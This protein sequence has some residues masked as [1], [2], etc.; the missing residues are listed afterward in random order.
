MVL[1]VG[2]FK[3]WR[4]TELRIFPIQNFAK[5]ATSI[6]GFLT[7]GR[8]V[9]V[10]ECVC[11]VSSNI[12]IYFLKPLTVLSS[13]SSLAMTPAASIPNCVALE[14][15]SMIILFRGEMTK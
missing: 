6:E 13:I 9:C 2:F 1:L 3:I 14:I 7:I 8:Q 11:F 12:L 5:L 4:T 15:W 10:D